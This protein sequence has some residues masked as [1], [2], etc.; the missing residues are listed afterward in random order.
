VSFFLTLLSELLD[1]LSWRL[2]CRP[3]ITQREYQYWFD[4]NPVVRNNGSVESLTLKRQLNAGGTN[5]IFLA[6]YSLVGK[7]SKNSKVPSEIVLKICKPYA[8]PGPARHHRIN[9]VLGSFADEIRINNLIRATNIEGVVQSFGGGNAGRFPYFKMEYIRGQSLDTYFTTELNRDE[10]IKRLAKLAYLA[11]TI[12]QLHYYHV[13]HKDLKPRNIIL[14]EDPDQI[15]NHKLVICDFGF[16]NSK[17]RDTVSIYGGQL[18]P[19]YAAPEQALMGEN[20]TPATDLFSFGVIAHEYLTGVSPFPRAMEIFAEDG[21]LIT[22]RYLNH[23]KNQRE[24]IFK[25][26]PEITDMLT[27]LT[28]FDS[29]VRTEKS[30]DLFDLA[31]RI[32][33]IVN[34]EG[35]RDVNTDFL[36]NQLG[37]YGR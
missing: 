24:I 31:H 8:A 1:R 27:V 10:I 5:D 30:P 19:G 29:G 11:N 15:K 34:A 23:F 21:Y 2:V 32:R 12:S 37:E 18:T 13:I 9:M 26:F 4:R 7:N 20:L 17:L 28:E 3:F 35:Y 16:S 36:W 6:D 22:E 14:C 25:E 33:E